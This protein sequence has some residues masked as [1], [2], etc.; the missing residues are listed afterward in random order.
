MARTSSSRSP[1]GSDTRAL[2]KVT[3]KH[4]MRMVEQIAC[5]AL[6]VGQQH[7]LTP[8]QGREA[9]K[10]A[11]TRLRKSPYRLQEATEFH[12][13]QQ[14]ANLLD[15]W[16]RDPQYLDEAG[17]PRA[18]PLA[19][20]KSFATL[21]VKFVPQLKPA[22]LAALLTREGLLEPCAHRRVKPARR[23]AAFRSVNPLMLDRMPVLTRGLLG[24]ISHNISGKTGQRGTYCERGT[25]VDHFPIDRLPEFAEFMKGMAQALL[26]RADVW[27]HART[28]RP[29][30]RSRPTARIGVEVFTYVEDEPLPKK[31]GPRSR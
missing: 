22:A 12:T 14:M 1:D 21:A 24:T 31:R 25:H 19:G 28:V 11:Q 26:D 6:E 27:A 15:A 20:P 10:N 16:Y 8:A 3:P 2:L 17:R 9:L 29:G 4:L 18:L 7:G 23:A 13:L 5:V 30:Q